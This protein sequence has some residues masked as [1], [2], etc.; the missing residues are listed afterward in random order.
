M[1]TNSF[2]VPHAN[3]TGNELLWEMPVNANA[4]EGSFVSS[5]MAII[6]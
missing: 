3:S 4:N 2:L 5:A 6:Y 1:S